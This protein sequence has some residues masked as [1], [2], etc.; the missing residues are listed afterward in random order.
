MSADLILQTYSTDDEHELQGALQDLSTSGISSEV[1]IHQPGPQASLEWLVPTALML[2]AGD[3]YF[4]AFL[5]EAGKDNYQA[6]KRFTSKIFEKTLG[7]EATVTRT[8]RTVFGTTKP[9][10]AFSGNLSIMYR[11][12]A[13]WTAKLMFPLDVTSAE[14]EVACQRFAGLVSGYV[15]DPMSSPL[16]I[17]AALALREKARGLPPSLQ[18]PDLQKT[19]RLLVYWNASAECFYVPDPIASGRSGK[20]VAHRLG[21]EA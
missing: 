14:Y 15:A 8:I 7:K 18:N 19:V 17:E 3:K 6:L 13:G 12:A 4:G 5:E 21:A 20:L 10:V 11:S 16:A 9:D 1:K 2:W